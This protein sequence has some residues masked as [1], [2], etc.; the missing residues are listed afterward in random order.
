MLSSS[1]PRDWPSIVLMLVAGGGS[2]DE[3]VAL[4]VGSAVSGGVNVVQVRDR[5]APG[6]QMWSRVRRLRGV[7]GSRARLVVNDR[8]DVALLTGADGVQLPESGLP[9]APVRSFLPRSFRVGR[10]V[11]SVAAARQ[12]ELD[13]AD[14]LVLGTVFRSASHPDRAGAGL[15]LVTAV[16]SRVSIPVIAIGGVTPENALSCLDAGARGVAVVSGILGARDPH[17]AARAYA[18]AL[19]LE[20]E[21]Q[22]GLP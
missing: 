17:E 8:V 12:A 22:C 13:G 2:T 16:T 3:E 11:H 4:S 14:F 19:G 15:E 18:R 6:A 21:G 20:G 9:V 1:V 5:Q 7:C 10:S